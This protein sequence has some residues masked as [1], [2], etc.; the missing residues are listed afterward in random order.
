MTWEEAAA[1][2]RF[3]QATSHDQMMYLERTRQFYGNKR[4]N[5]TSNLILVKLQDSNNGERVGKLS[6]GGKQVASI[7][8]RIKPSTVILSMTT[9]QFLPSLGTY[10]EPGIVSPIKLSIN[11]YLNGQ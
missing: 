10:F 2:R 9:K 5:H 1:G 11:G 7:K 8:T 4:T 3:L 6:E